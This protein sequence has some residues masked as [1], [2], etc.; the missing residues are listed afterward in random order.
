[1][2]QTSDSYAGTEN[3]KQILLLRRI[4]KKIIPVRDQIIFRLILETGCKPK[5]LINIRPNNFE[6]TTCSLII[7]QE[8]K[9]R[10][11][12]LPLDLSLQLNLF[13]K[14]SQ[15]AE[16][17]QGQENSSEQKFV[18]DS[19]Q[20]AK[21]TTKT[22]C[23]VIINASIEFLHKKITPNKLRQ[24]FIMNSFSRTKSLAMTKN[25]AGISTLRQKYY[26]SEEQIKNIKDQI[27][28]EQHRLLLEI[29]YETGCTLNELINIK[30]KDLSL[31]STI[32]SII[33]RVEN[34]KQNKTRTSKISQ[35]LSL[36]LKLF[37]MNIGI[38]QDNFLFSTRQSPQMSDKRVF[39]LIREYAIQAGISGVSPQ[40]IRNSHIA[41]SLKSGKPQ[42][43]I[44]AQTGVNHLGVHH[45]GIVKM[46]QE[47]RA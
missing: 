45:Y 10:R 47:Q 7:G 11:I 9:Q 41:H 13:I 18:F 26:L 1:M 8:E 46:K 4:A 25:Q 30:V 37:V 29:L 44:E 33:I 34:S 20:S 16:Q 36:R 6:F 27:K 19:R 43:E 15:S 21:L 12:K 23:Q 17:T 38:P 35:N 22:I 28:D 14:N 24:L 39:Q 42:S 5:E 32:P 2:K 3:N 40:I 31:H